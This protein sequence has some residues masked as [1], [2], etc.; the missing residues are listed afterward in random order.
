L[1]PVPNSNE[2][3]CELAD[4]LAAMRPPRREPGAENWSG[5]LVGKTGLEDWRQSGSLH[6]GLPA[7]V[8]Y[9]TRMGCF[10]FSFLML[11]SVG[12]VGACLR[13]RHFFQWTEA[14]LARPEAVQRW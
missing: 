4:P 8:P 5:K 9:T 7:C 1:I 13:Q 3:G 2:T 14:K 10:R 11:L 12:S 6:R